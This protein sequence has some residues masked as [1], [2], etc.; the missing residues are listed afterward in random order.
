MHFVNGFQWSHH[1]LEFA[2]LPLPH[3]NDIDAVDLNII[4][5]AG[6]LEHSAAAID[7]FTHIAKVPTEYLTRGAQIQVGDV[8]TSLRCVYNRGPKNTVLGK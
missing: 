8:S 4:D 6:E 5:G 3:L 2:D 7:H 1:D